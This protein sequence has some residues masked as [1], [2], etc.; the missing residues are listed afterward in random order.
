MLNSCLWKSR[1]FFKCGFAEKKCKNFNI[2]RLFFIRAKNYCKN[3]S[4]WDQSQVSSSIRLEMSLLKKTCLSNDRQI[5]MGNSRII[6]VG[7]WAKF[8][9][10]WM[11]FLVW[12]KMVFLALFEI[13]FQNRIIFFRSWDLYISLFQSYVFSWI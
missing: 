2:L 7:D 4:I 9:C 11:I 3:S 8:L 12:A 6:L 13:F 5:W 10:N 1:F